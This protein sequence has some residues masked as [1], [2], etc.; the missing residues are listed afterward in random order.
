DIQ[1]NFYLKAGND[2]AED[3]VP[4]TVAAGDAYVATGNTLPV[5]PAVPKKKK[6]EVQV[7]TVDDVAKELQGMGKPAPAVKKP[8]ERP[9]K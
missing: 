3:K 7:L 1:Q 2:I 4:E 9:V 8:I 6:P 5:K